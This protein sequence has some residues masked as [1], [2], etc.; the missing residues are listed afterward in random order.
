MRL[1]LADFW[2]RGWY[3]SVIIKLKLNKSI[4]FWR[5]VAIFVGLTIAVRR[6]AVQAGLIFLRLCKVQ[7]V[8]KYSEDRR[9]VRRGRGQVTQKKIFDENSARIIQE[10]T[11]VR[12]VKDGIYLLTCRL[13]PHHVP[14]LLSSFGQRNSRTLSIVPLETNITRII[15]HC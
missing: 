10:I 13:F 8:G 5:G 2:K 7:D 9:L 14:L 12:F 6:H 1:Q 15:Y 11:S 4:Y 3:W